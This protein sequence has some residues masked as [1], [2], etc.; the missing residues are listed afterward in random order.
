MC[1]H[2]SGKCFHQAHII[3]R[4]LLLL[5]IFKHTLCVFCFVSANQDPAENA[6]DLD[7]DIAV[8]QSQVNLTCPLTQVDHSSLLICSTNSCF[9]V[10]C[11]SYLS[12]FLSY[13]IYIC[14]VCD[15]S[16]WFY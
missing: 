13:Y 5:E 2:T 3:Y 7:E 9:H 12:A 1:E 4:S 16:Y 8:T 6:E 14:L 11:F 15:Q 10:K